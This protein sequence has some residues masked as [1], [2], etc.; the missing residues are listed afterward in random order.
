LR[1]FRAFSRRS[2]SVADMMLS[3]WPRHLVALAE[4]MCR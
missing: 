3:D 4:Y 2:I 1:F